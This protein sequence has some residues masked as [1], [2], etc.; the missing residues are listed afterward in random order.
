MIYPCILAHEVYFFTFCLTSQGSICVIHA[1]FLVNA[2]M[3]VAEGVHPGYPYVIRSHGGNLATPLPVS[4]LR[5]IELMNGFFVARE[6]SDGKKVILPHFFFL[7]ICCC[8]HALCQSTLLK[9]TA[10]I[11]LGQDGQGGDSVFR[12]WLHLVFREAVAIDG[13]QAVLLSVRFSIYGRLRARSS[14]R[15]CLSQNTKLLLGSSLWCCGRHRG[16]HM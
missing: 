7:F 10:A 6:G 13:R 1:V 5:V 4:S 9:A 15:A 16:V 11:T 8:C 14:V 3:G 12:L 2:N